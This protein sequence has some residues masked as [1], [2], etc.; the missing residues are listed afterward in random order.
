MLYPSLSSLEKEMRELEDREDDGGGDGVKPLGAKGKHN[1]TTRWCTVFWRLFCNIVR[2]TPFE[3]GG[4]QKINMSD[5]RKS[6]GQTKVDLFFMSDAFPIR[7]KNASKQKKLTLGRNNI[8][9][10]WGL[11]FVRRGVHKGGE[12]ATQVCAKY[13]SL[14]IAYF[15]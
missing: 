5:G 7:M 6:W 10:V 9:F 1:V 13:L 14:F 15:S 8:S 12:I 4:D 11:M 2:L 3:A